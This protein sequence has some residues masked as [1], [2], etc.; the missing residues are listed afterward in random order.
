MT[1]WP[2]TRYCGCASVSPLGVSAPPSPVDTPNRAP[3]VQRTGEVAANS[4][5]AAPPGAR[6]T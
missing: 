1:R 3:G 5:V 6:S 4:H 2:V